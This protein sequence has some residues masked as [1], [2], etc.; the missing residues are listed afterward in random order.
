MRYLIYKVLS[1]WV[2]GTLQRWTEAKF[3]SF[4]EFGE[5]WRQHYPA[6]MS[7]RT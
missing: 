2:E 3:V 5:I 1:T 6:G 4:G 7:R